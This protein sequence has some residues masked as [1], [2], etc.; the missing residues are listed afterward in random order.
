M[1]A[2]EKKEKVEDPSNYGKVR[3]AFKDVLAER[4]AQ[5]FAATGSALKA[6]HKGELKH[7]WQMAEVIKDAMAEITPGKW[8]VVVGKEYGSYVTHEA[9][10]L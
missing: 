3:I 2:K 4:Q 5:M 9:G 8:H 10:T 6:F 1:A 7:F